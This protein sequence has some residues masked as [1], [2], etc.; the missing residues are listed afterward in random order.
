MTTGTAPSDKTELRRRDFRT[1]LLLAGLS[2]FFL[3]RTA[4]LPFY[5]VSAAGVEGAWYNSAALVPYLIFGALLVLSLALLAVALRE[6]GAPAGLSWPRID[7]RAQRVMAISAIM[8]AYIVALVPRVDF[9]IASALVILALILAFHQQRRAPTVIALTAIL[10]PAAYALAV[11]FP[12]A[13]WQAP[14]DDDWVALVA[15]VA[16]VVVGLA[17]ARRHHGR[18]GAV[19]GYAPV[20]AVVLPLCLVCAM[21]FGFRQNVPN[22][23]G[24]IFTQIQYHYFVTLRP[25]WTEAR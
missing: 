21:A 9:V 17:E 19:L 2:I 24:L 14:H 20:L 8:L 10:V 3:I 18:I 12:P 13:E 11:H 16:L 25:L 5:E 4:A 6:G 23:G 22:R 15:F 1:A 7:T